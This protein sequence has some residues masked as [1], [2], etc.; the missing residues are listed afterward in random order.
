MPRIRRMSL[1]SIE[2]LEQRICPSVT[3]AHLDLDSDG[4]ADDLKIVGGNESSKINITDVGMAQGKILLD[5]DI[6]GDG[7]FADAGDLQGSLLEVLDDTCVIKLQLGGGNDQVVYALSQHLS[8]SQRQLAVDL[9]NGN[10]EFIFQG[11]GKTVG[12]ESAL[13]ISLQ[14]GAGNDLLHLQ[15][16]HVIES[17]VVIDGIMGAGNDKVGMD[18]TFSPGIVI[19]YYAVLDINID[20]GKGTNSLFADLGCHVGIFSQGA[21]RLDILGGSGI[22]TIS[23]LTG[24]AVGNGSLSSALSINADLGGG[25][26]SFSCFTARLDV[27]LN[28][29]LLISAS[30][31]AG[32]DGMAVGFLSTALPSRQTELKGLAQFELL[33]GAGNDELYSLFND[34][35]SKLLLNG[36][37]LVVLNGGDGADILTASLKLTTNVSTGNYSLVALGGAGKDSFVVDV[38][39]AGFTL[40]FGTAGKLLIDGG[41][42][43]DKLQAIAPAAILDVQLVETFV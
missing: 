6:N 39:A 32:N 8:A 19:D 14:A 30:G 5:L 1:S 22:D 21:A 4:S 24:F 26:D 41:L 27:N 33:G 42:Q 11:I 29:S 2:S 3:V 20:L 35:Y 18:T 9:G 16:P 38:H 17:E 43:A 23:M 10:D 36:Q 13:R 12:N 37:L 31:G 25:N 40:T 34:D 7:D 28:S 15:L